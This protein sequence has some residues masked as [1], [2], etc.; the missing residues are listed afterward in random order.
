MNSISAIKPL[1][2]VEL[3]VAVSQLHQAGLVVTKSRLR[4]FSIFYTNSDGE[5]NVNDVYRALQKNH[6]PASLS[7]IYGVLNHFSLSGI[8]S[9]QTINGMK[10]YSFNNG[11]NSSHI[12]CSK[13]GHR[14]K[15]SDGNLENTCR[16]K[17][18]SLGFDA[19][20]F[21]VSIN[22]LCKCCAA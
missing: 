16:D 12:T 17:M 1:D 13:C 19:A 21:S 11:S 22:G 3:N 9:V 4:I 15:F 6:T 18:E 5:L 7:T 14:Q 10:L 2:S 20:V 8:L